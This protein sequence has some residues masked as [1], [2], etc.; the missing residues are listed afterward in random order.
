[1]GIEGQNQFVFELVA[2]TFVVQSL[3]TQSGCLGVSELGFRIECIAEATF[4]RYRFSGFRFFRVS[5]VMGAFVSDFVALE[6]GLN[7]YGWIS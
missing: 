2:R 3:G 6:R 7:I 4:R 5:E 1:M